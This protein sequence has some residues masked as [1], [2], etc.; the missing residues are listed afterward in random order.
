M[1]VL[2]D[3]IMTEFEEEGGFVTD[4]IKASTDIFKETT[5]L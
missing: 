5:I 3:Y 2:I 4:M 1:R